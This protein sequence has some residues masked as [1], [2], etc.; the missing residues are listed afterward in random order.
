MSGA[1]DCLFFFF[2]PSSSLPP[3]RLLPGKEKV[4]AER[5]NRT[6]MVVPAC[7]RDPTG[8]FSPPFSSFFFRHGAGERILGRAIE[9]DRRA[10]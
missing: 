8:A 7:C 2:F 6:P 4:R 9:R 10:R 1:Q 3:C 5:E